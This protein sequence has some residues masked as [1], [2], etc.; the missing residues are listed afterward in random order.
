[1]QRLRHSGRATLVFYAKLII[2]DFRGRV[3]IGFTGD[4]I[5]TQRGGHYGP[6]LSTKRLSF[7]CQVCM[8]LIGDMSVTGM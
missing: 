3:V 7:G 2:P 5:N 4:T 8:A 1:M 6:I